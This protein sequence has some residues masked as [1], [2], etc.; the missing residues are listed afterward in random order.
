MERGTKH[1][2]ETIGKLRISQIKRMKNKVERERISNSLKGNTPWNKGLTKENNKILKKQSEHYKKI[3]GINKGRAWNKGLKNL[4]IQTKES[5]IKRSLALKKY[6]FNNPQEL[7]RLMKI[8]KNKVFN[9]K[10]ELEM[11]NILNELHLSFIPQFKFY[12]LYNDF[13][14]V[15]T[16]DFKLKEFPIII[17]CDGSYWHNL[18]N[19]KEKD[20]VKTKY[21]E[22]LGY[23]VLRFYDYEI[24]KQKE[25]IKEK[26]EL[27]VARA[28]T[29]TI[30]SL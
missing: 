25:I 10:I 5:N 2:K 18:D 30:T 8:C 16:A 23:N 1:L 19:I 11:I 12:Y 22:S 20:I 21:L 29:M 14:C 4:Y 3:G 24:Y 13:K 27:T 15:A 26:I 9:T 17:E 7:K 6:L 28:G